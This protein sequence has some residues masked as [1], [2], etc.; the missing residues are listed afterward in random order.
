M[1]C[2]AHYIPEN[3]YL[4]LWFRIIISFIAKG[5][6]PAGFYVGH[7]HFDSK[8]YGLLLNEKGQYRVKSIRSKGTDSVIART[9]KYVV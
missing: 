3:V 2:N 4:I 1:H 8:M 5:C 7:L 9:S 6:V